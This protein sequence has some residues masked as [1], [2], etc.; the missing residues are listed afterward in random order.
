MTGSIQFLNQPSACWFFTECNGLQITG[1]QTIK[2]FTLTS[3]LL[4]M[5]VLMKIIRV[6]IVS[7]TKHFPEPLF[8][9]SYIAYC[10]ENKDRKQRP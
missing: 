6:Q 2:A 1:L 7:P 4:G 3:I 8:K 9:E 5:P 10:V